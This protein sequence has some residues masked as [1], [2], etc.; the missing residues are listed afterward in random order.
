[1]S[2]PLVPG[3]LQ[4]A[5]EG[6]AALVPG[7]PRRAKRAREGG[8]A[9]WVDGEGL[10]EGEP[11]YADK[12]FDLQE[13]KQDKWENELREAGYDDDI[14]INVLYKKH[15]DLRK[16][17]REA[18]LYINIAHER[19][20]IIEERNSDQRKAKIRRMLTAPVRAL[21]SA[22]SALVDAV[23]PDSSVDIMSG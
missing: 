20:R 22:G 7:L 6:R 1:M 3:R 8:Q 13:W 14:D 10:E 4:A 16:K 18:K 12:K 2:G 21:Q 19:D 17:L 5:P 11:L 23:I 15:E 9:G